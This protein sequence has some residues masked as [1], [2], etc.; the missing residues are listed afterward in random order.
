M[1]TTLNILSGKRG[2]LRFPLLEWVPIL[3]YSLSRSTPVRS[4]RTAKTTNY[5]KRIFGPESGTFEVTGIGEMP[6]WSTINYSP[7]TIR[8]GWNTTPG[9]S[10]KYID[11][12]V[13]LKQIVVQMNFSKT[14][15]VNC[16]W[17]ATFDAF[18]LI[19]IELE[20]SEL[21]E[22]IG[23]YS[24]SCAIYPYSDD[25]Y[26]SAYAHVIQEVVSATY[27]KTINR[28]NTYTA[29][30][31]Y[32][33][34]C[35]PEGYDTTLSL[36]VQGHFPHWLEDIG[37]TKYTY[38]L[39]DDVGTYWELLNGTILSVENFVTNIQTGELLSATVNIGSNYG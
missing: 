16:T 31:P 26:W 28:L 24:G 33:P 13:A 8:F 21:D 19:E 9:T 37:L 4:L 35:T 5:P 3:R 32:N 27:T 18:E 30:S 22:I 10:Y 2:F 1:T 23:C 7:E 38:R 34:T 17:T 29:R 20:P 25:G 14:T 15:E 39:Y 6:G 11:L 12:K 36:L